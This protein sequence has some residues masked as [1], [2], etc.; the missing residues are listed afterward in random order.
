MSGLLMTGTSSDAGKSALVTGLCR[1][2]ARRGI[3]VV[4]FKSQN[5]S[6]NSMVCPDGAEIGRAQYL[7]ATAA[8]AVPNA[9][10]NPV[11]LKPGTDRRSFI[12]LMGSPAGELDAGEYATGRRRLA[13]AA[14]EAY[15]D[16]AGHHELVVCEGAGS[17]AEI[18]LRAGDYVNMGLARKFN[19][20]TVV[21]GDIDR[22]GVLASLYGTWALLD[23]A[24]RAL[25]RGYVI[26]KFRGDASILAPGLAE[27]SGRTGMTG[28]GVLP[29]LPGVWI[30]GEDAL[31]VDRW[32]REE[33]AG[34]ASLRV[35]AVRLPRISNATD[36]D[37]LA[38]EPGVDVQ[39]TDDPRVAARADL[40]VLPGSR[41]TVEDL[42]WLTERGIGR[43]AAR[44]HAEGRPVLGICGGYEMLGE[45][46]DDEVESRTGTVPG[47]GLL[48]MRVRFAGDKTVRVASYDYR[49][50][51]V[52]GYE[53]HHGICETS[54]GEPFLDGV[55]SAG[56][57]GTMLHGSLENDDFRRA[58]LSEV[59]AIAGSG[60]TPDES[61][62]GYA[63]RR[64][65]MISTLAD[66]M[67]ENLDVDALLALAREGD[68]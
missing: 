55:R 61:A 32:A 23:E 5:M 68:R 49:G 27:I 56:T 1:A 51:T 59:A 2:A 3:D 60:W 47:L 13:Q 6:N 4:P 54:G 64:E 31:Q 63:Q 44:R 40:L 17:P 66:A 8:G 33:G 7:Q 58:F 39:V 53:I 65:R 26:N 36:I 35:A 48:P 34:S 22:G 62:P 38:A 37:A 21:I 45:R 25:L 52:T 50:M 18:N 28:Y 16:L 67:E 43:V 15:A 19:L 14:F 57:W 10:M 30:D 46:L 20:P 29:W 12:V 9:A 24:D 11:L 42:A 41:S